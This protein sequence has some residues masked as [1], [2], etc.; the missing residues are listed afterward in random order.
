MHP[1]SGKSDLRIKGFYAATSDKIGENLL[2]RVHRVTMA[3]SDSTVKLWRCEDRTWELLV[4]ADYLTACLTSAIR[5]ENQQFDFVTAATDGYVALWKFEEHAAS[6]SWS[7]RQ[8]IHQNAIHVSIACKLADDSILL[9]TGGD[10][11]A[12]GLTRICF[13]SNLAATTLLIYRAHAA[14]VTGLAIVHKD[15]TTL[16]LASA[17]IDQRLKLWRIDVDITKPA[18]DGISFKKT[19]YV[20]TAVADVSSLEI[21]QNEDRDICLLVCGVGMDSWSLPTFNKRGRW[22]SH[23]RTCDL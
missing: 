9:I 19:Q 3:Y 2:V 16:W 5:I 21:C 20:F 1:R 6:L 22:G 15:E 4:A 8:K 12:I 17:G 18:V 11:N 7:V 23:L 10:D 13:G 14:A